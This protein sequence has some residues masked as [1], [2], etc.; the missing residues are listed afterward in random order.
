VLGDGD[1]LHVRL[2]DVLVQDGWIAQTQREIELA[3]VV[4]LDARL[5]EWTSLNSLD[6]SVIVP[7]ILVLLQLV[8]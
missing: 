1:S 3:V 8:V 5:V 6:A 2:A 7:E 4:V